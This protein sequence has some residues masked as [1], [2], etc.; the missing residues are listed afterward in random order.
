MAVKRSGQ[1]SLADALVAPGSG[2]KGRLDRLERLVKWYRF[3][4]LLK[5]LRDEAGVILRRGTMLDATIIE[6]AAGR[7]PRETAPRARH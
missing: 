3:E 4:K 5:G 6:A 7:P 1:L 2:C